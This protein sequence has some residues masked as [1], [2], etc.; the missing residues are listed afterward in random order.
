VSDISSDVLFS[1]RYEG[2]PREI[3]AQTLLG[4]LNSISGLIQELSRQEPLSDQFR[5]KVRTNRPG[6]FIV[7][8]A[9]SPDTIES[10]KSLF[11]AD[12][13]KVAASIVAMV[14]G[15]L[16]I[17]KH[18]KRE[19]PRQ[20]REEDNEVHLE[21]SE[22]NI[23]IVDKRTY[24]VYTQN[25]QVEKLLDQNFRTLS[26]DPTVERF[27][28]A[29]STDAPM[30]EADRA[31]FTDMVVGSR[32]DNDGFRTTTERALVSIVK[33]SFEKRFKWKFVHRGRHIGAD[34]EDGV[35]LKRIDER[36]E[37]FAK[38]D[39]LEVDLEIHQEYDPGLLTYLDRSYTVTKVH[40]HVSA[41]K[42]AELDFRG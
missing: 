33:P 1:L 36:R 20:V 9:L 19:P 32:A 30:F 39:L 11:S 34:L 18:L 5:L 17:R 31:D 25:T 41:G 35:F 16:T 6:S 24:N 15:L 22:G 3:D 23:T 2:E 4:S 40:N 29:D 37:M 7:D 28:V 13:I 14:A 38:G 12:N 21:N 27:S 8:L 26:A 10:M 42:Q